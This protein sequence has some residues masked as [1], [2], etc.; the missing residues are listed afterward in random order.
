[1]NTIGIHSLVFTPT[2]SEESVRPVFETAQEI[3][4]DWI[5]CLIMDAD[6]IDT[7]FS[8]RLQ[9]EYGIG[10]ITTMAG[11]LAAD[12]G[13][14]DLEVVA[15]SERLLHQ[16]LDHAAAM[17][18]PF[19]SGPGFSAVNRYTE[20]P[21]PAAMD[22]AIE[23]YGRVADRARSMGLRVGLEALNRYESN[24]VNTL[25]QAARI[26]RDAGPDVLFVHADLFHMRIEEGKFADAVADVADVL[27]YVHIAESHRGALGTGNTDWADFFKALAVARYTGPITF[28]S[29]SPAVLGPD[30]AGAV[31]L[32]RD[33]WDDPAGIALS[34]YMQ[35]RD[36]INNT[37]RE[38]ADA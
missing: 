21:A 17:G 25:G 26:V 6:D 10:V 29:F 31:A 30:W 32:W 16:C 37:A 8:R 35:I 38:I 27:G 9:E 4:Y 12:M 20:P 19:I 24:F 11:N 2:W 15:R 1:V 7:A 13:S 28:E 5:E 14:A 36:H 22:R 34:A 33:P 18:S 23:I 3:G